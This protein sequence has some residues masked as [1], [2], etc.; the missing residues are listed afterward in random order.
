MKKAYQNFFAMIVTS[1]ILMYGIMFLN[2]YQMSHVLF[3]EMRLYMTILSSSV[4]M[5]VM[6]FFMRGMLK[7]K[8]INI[9]IVTLSVLIFASSLFLVRSQSLVDDVDYM[10]AM[11]PHHSI[12]ILASERAQISDP[13]VKKLA[14]DIIEAQKNE[15]QVMKDL[16]EELRSAD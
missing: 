6:L 5:L 16:I 3:S 1:G 4:M 14:D 9:G 15:I 7:D 10:Q 13:R 11:I 8:K 2:T 12:A